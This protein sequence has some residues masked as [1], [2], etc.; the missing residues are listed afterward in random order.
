[1]LY[2]PGDPSHRLFKYVKR[3]LDRRSFLV[4]DEPF[5]AWRA[6]RGYVGNVAHA[7]TVASINHAA[8]NRIYNVGEASAYSELEWIH[9]IADVMNWSVKVNSVAKS[10]LPLQLV[11]QHLTKQNWIMDTTRIREELDYKE[12]YTLDEA[13]RATVQWEKDNPPIALH[14]KDFPLFDYDAEDLF[15]SGCE[16][17]DTL[18]A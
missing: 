10:K 11:N 17:S 13:L 14:P 18:E 15:I 6:T 12:L 16:Q 9:A 2:G 4:L 3:S 7:I 5:S 1:M 8:A